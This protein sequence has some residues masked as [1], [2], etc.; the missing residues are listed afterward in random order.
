MKRYKENVDTLFGN[1]PVR[2]EI[3]VHITKQ[4]TS[5]SGVHLEKL[6]VP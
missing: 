5:W 4:L 6:I 3:T 2:K 1:A